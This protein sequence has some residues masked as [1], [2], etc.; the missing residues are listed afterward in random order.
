M[1]QRLNLQILWVQQP[2]SENAKVRGIDWR[3]DEHI[4]AVG[5]VFRYFLSYPWKWK[6]NSFSLFKGYNTGKVLLIDVENQ[7]IIHTLNLQND[8]ACV[9]WTQNTTESYDDFDD[10][11]GNTK[12]VS[13]NSTCKAQHSTN[14]EC[15][16]FSLQM[17]T[18]CICRSY[19]TSI[20][21][22]RI[23]GK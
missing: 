6:P 21:W 19:R 9:S 23:R 4:L 12:L 20:R 8:V 1:V 13:S 18:R 3:P 22:H 16:N 7:Q 17:V 2:P 14:L 15:Y 5:N 11:Q 10:L